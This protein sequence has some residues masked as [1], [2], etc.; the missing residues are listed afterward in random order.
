MIII[1]GGDL[2]IDLTFYWAKHSSSSIIGN[3]S[4]FGLSFELMFGKKLVIDG[5]S[6]F[7][8][9]LDSMPVTVPDDNAFE[10]TRLDPPLPQE[11]RE[12]LLFMLNKM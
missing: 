2:E 8:E 10:L 5:N 12:I 9:L 11:D 6:Y 7:F 4:A 3:G 1:D